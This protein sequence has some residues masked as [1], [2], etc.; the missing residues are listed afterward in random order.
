LQLLQEEAMKVLNLV[1]LVLVIVGGLDLG[2]AGLV[3][4]DVLAMIFGGAAG[5]LTRIVYAIVGLSALWQLVPLVYAF[6][7]GEISAERHLGA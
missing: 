4:V 7:S 3:G 5:A 6:G 1:T 2:I